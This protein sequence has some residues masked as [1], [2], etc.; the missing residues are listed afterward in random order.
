MSGAWNY[1]VKRINWV[2][3]AVKYR[4]MLSNVVRVP[5]RRYGGSDTSRLGRFFTFSGS[6][7]SSLSSVTKGVTLCDS[8][9]GGPT[10]QSIG[11]F[12][13]KRD[14]GNCSA[15]MAFADHHV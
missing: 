14:I 8:S 6:A 4:G 1:V 9:I 2:T 5:N 15:R 3:V 13:G 10:V 12:E 11:L 7:R